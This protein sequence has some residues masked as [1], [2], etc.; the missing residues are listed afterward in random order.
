MSK[1]LVIEDDATIRETVTYSLKFA[2]F[3]VST[4]GDGKTGIEQALREKPDLIL[5]DIMLPELNGFEFCRKLK[6]KSEKTA[7]LMLTALDTA[8]LKKRTAFLSGSFLRSIDLLLILVLVVILA[9]VAD[10]GCFEILDRFGAADFRAV[11]FVFLH[12]KITFIFKRISFHAVF[13]S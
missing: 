5:L 6:A 13:T 3:D 1:I 7:V 12:R 9:A 2:G 8:L 11:I 4:A 10:C